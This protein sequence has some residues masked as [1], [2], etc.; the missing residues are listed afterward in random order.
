MFSRTFSQ[1]DLHTCELHFLLLQSQRYW[2]ESVRVFKVYIQII[3]FS[4]K[5]PQ[6]SRCRFQIWKFLV[7]LASW[8]S[9]FCRYYYFHPVR[10][11]FCQHDIYCVYFNWFSVDVPHKVYKDRVKVGMCREF[12]CQT[13]YFDFYRSIVI[14][15]YHKWMSIKNY[16]FIFQFE[17]P[18]HVSKQVF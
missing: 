1:I 2:T 16:I 3:I 17:F 5:N 10:H 7:L 15:L 14:N 13:K 12:H 18:S 8:I 4:G 11:I 6:D 9:Q